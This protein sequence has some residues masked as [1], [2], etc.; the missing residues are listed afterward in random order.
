MPGLFRSQPDTLLI[1]LSDRD[2]YLGVLRGALDT[3]DATD[4]P[5]LERALALVETAD[6]PD[7]A[8]LRGRWAL[9]RIEAAGV[10]AR[11]DS[12]VAIKAL[13]KAEPG[14]SL[15]QAVALSKEAAAVAAR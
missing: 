3:A 11:P 6:A 13:R 7:P 14:L 8:G 5:G 4:R 15:A 2:T 1:A 9:D 12:I 10:E